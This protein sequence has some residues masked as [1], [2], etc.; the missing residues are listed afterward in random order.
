MSK[1]KRLL[2][3]MF[4]VESTGTDLSPEQEHEIR[5]A[6][7]KLVSIMHH[8][9]PETFF[10]ADSEVLKEIGKDNWK[11]YVG[12][13]EG[14]LAAKDQYTYGLELHTDVLELI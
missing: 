11:D 9:V 3:K 7:R 2:V 6:N 12:F 10:Y 5:M 4:C 14:W 13:V 1:I 8:E